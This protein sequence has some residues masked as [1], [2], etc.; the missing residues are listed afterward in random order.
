[1]KRFVEGKYGR[2]TLRFYP[3]PFRAPLR[4]FAV[5]VF[6][7]REEEVLVCDITGRGWCVPSGRVEPD[8]S[9]SEAGLREA[10]EEGGAVLDNV[11]YIGCYEIRDRNEVRWADCYT[12][13]VVE[14]GEITVKEESN[15]RKLVTLDQLPDLYHLWN[16]L[17]A[18][19][20]QH[21]HEVCTR[22][23]EWKA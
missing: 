12:G 23:N 10:V 4:S 11:Q 7:W 13:N 5:L 8:E 17:T 22:A 21:A 6:A 14:L 20:F 18:Q 9:S 15:G 16:E 3:A 19:V 1:M 2:Q